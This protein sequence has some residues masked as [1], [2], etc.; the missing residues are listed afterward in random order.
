[1][2][3]N[4]RNPPSPRLPRRSNLRL[5]S[6]LARSSSSPS[7]SYLKSSPTNSIQAWTANP[8]IHPIVPML[9][10]LPFG[11]GFLLIFMALTN[12]LTDLYA[13]QAASAMAALTCTRSICGAGLPFAT[14]KMYAT[15]DVHW[16]GSLLGFLALL[17]GMVPW[18]FWKWG[19]RIRGKGRFAK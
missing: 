7:P 12:Y 14:Q 1:M 18:V 10:G 5:L 15:L 8:H 11:I 16:A 2:V 17:V 3:P 9:A 19:A 13:D 6:L 4:P